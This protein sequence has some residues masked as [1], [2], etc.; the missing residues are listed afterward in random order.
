MA[1]SMRASGEH[2]AQHACMPRHCCVHHPCVHHPCV[3]LPLHLHHSLNVLLKNV[4][5]AC[6]GAIGFYLFG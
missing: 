4:L 5:D 1:I 6:M 3:L 2:R